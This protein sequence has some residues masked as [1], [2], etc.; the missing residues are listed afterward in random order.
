MRLTV[1]GASGATGREVVTQA[2]AGG[3]EVTAVV[4]D[5]S[6]IGVDPDPRLRIEVA[7]IMVPDAIVDVVA[8]RDAVVSTVGTRGHG[9]TTVRRDSARSIVEAMR[10]AGTS[11]LVVV[12]ASGPFTEG[13]GLLIRTLAKPI[14]RRVLA[15]AFADML[16]MEEVVRES[17]LDW[18]ILRP[19]ALTDGRATGRYR[20]ARERN[21]HRGYRVSRADLAHL[22]L[23]ACLDTETH[24]AAISIAG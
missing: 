24:G 6:R 11:R 5:A 7:D 21:V 20:T 10:R 15:N 22:A 14:L 12:G 17:G 3:H 18:T 19:P 9:P 23:A 2:L 1:F 13:D 8:E 4:R 16:A